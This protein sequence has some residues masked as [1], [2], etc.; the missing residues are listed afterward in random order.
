MEPPGPVQVTVTD[1][2]LAGL[3]DWLP[4]VEPTDTA[5]VLLQLVA[6]CELQ[7]NVELCPV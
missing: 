7:L 2:L 5:P 6:Y 1:V 3:I 4:A